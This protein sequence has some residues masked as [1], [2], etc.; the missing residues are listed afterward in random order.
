MPDRICKLIADY[1][2]DEP[3]EPDELA[4]CEGCG[5]PF[6]LASHGEW[7]NC[8]GYYYC[9]TDKDCWGEHE[10]DCTR[11]DCPFNQGSENEVRTSLSVLICSN[12]VTI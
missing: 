4:I 10:D 7:G 9:G 12:F 8:H 3:E 6:A 11:S 5:A 1:A 2:R